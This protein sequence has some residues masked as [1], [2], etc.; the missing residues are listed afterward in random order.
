ML[1]SEAR[2]LFPAASERTYLNSAGTGIC[3]T[4]SAA[5][6]SA[7]LEEAQ[8]SP[9]AA[10][11]G[12][13]ADR[14]RGAAA[15]LINARKDQIGLT[16]STSLALQ[17][18]ADCVPLRRGD[19]VVTDN[20]EFMSVVLPWIEK[21]RRED[22]ALRVVKHEAGRVPVE[23]I[24]D[25]INGNTR[26]IVVSSVKWTNGF[27]LDLKSLAAACRSR[28]IPLIVDA[29]QQIGPLPL[30]VS[31]CPVDFLIC[32]GHKWLTSPAAVGFIYASDFFAANFR[33]TLSY[34][35][36]AAPPTGSWLSAW[37]NP[38]FD[39]I[40]VYDLKPDASRFEMGVHHAALASAGLAGALSIFSEFGTAQTARHVLKLGDRLVEGL[41]KMDFIVVSPE[42]P[43]ER[44]GITTFRALTTV[45][46]DVALRDF[47]SNR[48][49]DVSVRFT[50]GIGGVRVS[51]H[52]Y[53]S[54]DDVD[55]LLDL[56]LE[57]RATRR[58]GQVG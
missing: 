36:T 52:L 55:R 34:A 20:L 10:H 31:D 37:L 49:V 5:E 33:P 45:E 17:I 35:P 24:V 9:Y 54:E 29:I 47:L 8:H 4:R 27:R 39:P 30:D 7:F 11:H 38:D 40:Q 44:S 41:K 16:P 48:K 51:C 23:K 25:Q 28:N 21:C 22:A 12:N 3:S 43:A 46:D 57:W 15:Q 56:C 32:G 42:A 50:S 13:Q 58:S 1:Q 14:A 53:N 2:A 18:A 6:V 19:N 26:A